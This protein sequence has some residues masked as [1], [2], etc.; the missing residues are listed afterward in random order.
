[1]SFQ[2]LW[3][4]CF[5]VGSFGFGL[6]CGCDTFL[7]FDSLPKRKEAY[8]VGASTFPFIPVQCILHFFYSQPFSHCVSFL[9]LSIQFSKTIS[10]RIRLPYD[11]YSVKFYLVNKWRWV[12]SNHR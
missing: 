1:M 3:L 8:S 12:E 5:L 7:E 10:N 9:F 2:G 11:R 4:G 6:R